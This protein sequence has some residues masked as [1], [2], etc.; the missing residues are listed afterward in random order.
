MESAMLVSLI[1]DKVDD[2]FGF[3]GRGDNH[4]VFAKVDFADCI[5]DGKALQEH[6][7]KGVNA[8][9]PT[10]HRASRAYELFLVKV[11]SLHGGKMQGTFP[12][13]A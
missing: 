8:R 13:H 7:D 11:C 2:I 5:I 4:N 6:T 12:V 3:F 10:K 9:H 1:M